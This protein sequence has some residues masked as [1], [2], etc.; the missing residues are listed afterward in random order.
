MAAPATVACAPLEYAPG[1]PVRRRKLVRRIVRLL[2]ILSAGL[3]V[4]R[5]GPAAW[6]RAKL[7]YWQR[8]CLTFRFPPDVVLYERDP[9]KAAALL[10]KPNS[11]YVPVPYYTANASWAYSPVVAVTHADFQP[12]CLREFNARSSAGSAPG[13]RGVAFL[14]ERRTPAGK[15]RL[16]V[17][18]TTHW[19]D[20]RPHWDWELFDPAGPTAG[21]KLLN[22]GGDGSPF[23]FMSGYS[24]GVA[25]LGRL[26]PGQSD[27][28]DPTRFTLPWSIPGQP[29]ALYH[30]RLTDDG[31]VEIIRRDGTE[32]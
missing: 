22:T 1:A 8:Q 10:A 28:A 7:L 21:A 27:P 17:V 11:D 29:T 32:P 12:R 24:L 5:W 9:A 13:S 2:L 31:Q 30:G 26:G 3:V 25:I 19:G 6:D 18:Y 4:W 23:N 14:H 15:R 20:A 16:I